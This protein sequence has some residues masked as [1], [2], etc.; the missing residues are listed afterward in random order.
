MII[1]VSFYAEADP[2]IGDS[3]IIFYKLIKVRQYWI[4][5]FKTQIDYGTEKEMQTL[6]ANLNKN[7]GTP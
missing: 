6:A 7:I 2:Q 5:K 1:K 3:D 4:F